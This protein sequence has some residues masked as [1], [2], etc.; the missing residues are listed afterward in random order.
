MIS[1]RSFLKL[2]GIGGAGVALGV[3]LPAAPIETPTIAV[4]K[5]AGTIPV[6]QELIDDACLS[7]VPSIWSDQLWKK[8]RIP[9]GF[10][11]YTFPLDDEMEENDDND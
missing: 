10:E 3:K 11:T 1:R 4:S 7:W 2:L 8:V 9:P 6:S 5:L